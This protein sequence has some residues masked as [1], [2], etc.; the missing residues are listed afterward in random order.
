LA[1]HR[2]NSRSDRRPKSD[3]IVGLGDRSAHWFIAS[4]AVESGIAPNV[5]L[6]QS[7]RMLWTMGR[8][9]TAK[10]LPKK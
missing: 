8:W 7:D 3:K 10:N 5:L 2:R 6:E 9:I 4:L 1:G